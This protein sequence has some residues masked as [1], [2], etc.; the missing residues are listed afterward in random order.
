MSG[1]RI[2]CFGCHDTYPDL[3]SYKAHSKSA[4]CMLSGETWVSE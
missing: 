1:S 2:K 4:D 3:P